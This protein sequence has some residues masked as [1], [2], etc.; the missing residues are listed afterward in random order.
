MS[1]ITP[2]GRRHLPVYKYKGEDRSLLYKYFGSPFAQY[3]V[4][5]WT[6]RTTAPNTITLVGLLFQVLAYVVLASWSKNFEE[7]VPDAACYLAAAC[8]FIYATLDN[9]DGKQARRVGASSPL[10]LLFD[11]G[12]DA[13]N[14]GMVGSLVFGMVIGAGGATW[15]MYALWAC[16][17]SVFFVNTWEE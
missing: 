8:L 1:Y 2:A 16:V 9:M 4:D 17:V 11:H 15:R 7:P 3:W 5:N 12:C 13:I 6:P 10:G 14:T